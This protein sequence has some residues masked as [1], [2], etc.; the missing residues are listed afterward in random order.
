[1]EQAL[2]TQETPH[3]DYSHPSL[4]KTIKDLNLDGLSLKEKA[5]KIYLY[6]RDGWKY[7]PYKLELNP[8][9]WPASK[10]MARD[11]GHCIDKSVLL[12]ALLR[13]V[14][15]P[16]RIHLVKVRNHIGVERIIEKL[17]SDELTPHAY[18]EVY[19]NGK[20]VGATPAFNAHLCH[21]LNVAVLEFDGENDSLFQEFDKEGGQF[22]E[23]LDDYGH[24]VDLPIEFIVNNLKEH[25]PNVVWEG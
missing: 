5:I 8:D 20:W 16:A 25:Y 4:Q 6:V 23:Y 14:D 21:F 13:A 19:I 24:F 17:G 12:I 22:M 18:V 2:Y 15:I 3:Y 1:M 11:Y 9:N 7:N 10:V